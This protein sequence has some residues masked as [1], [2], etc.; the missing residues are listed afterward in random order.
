MSR[1]W[2]G[3]GSPQSISATDADHAWA[4][5]TCPPGGGQAS[6][7]P[8]LLATAELW[9]GWSFSFNRRYGVAAVGISFG[10]WPSRGNRS[11][12]RP[13]TSYGASSFYEQFNSGSHTGFGNYTGF[14]PS[15]PCY[16]VFVTATMY[17]HNISDSFSAVYQ[18]RSVR[19]PSLVKARLD[20]RKRPGSKESLKGTRRRSPF[21]H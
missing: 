9:L 1:R 10:G 17:Q 7:Q 5:I 20:C 6:C 15:I 3:A 18:R 19:T 14:P 2:H 16:A 11:R 21:V 13:G 4:L 8:E 12:G